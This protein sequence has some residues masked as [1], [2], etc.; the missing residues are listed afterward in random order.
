MCFNKA[1]LVCWRHRTDL[2]C[3]QAP[4]LVARSV[5]VFYSFRICVAYSNPSRD[6]CVDSALIEENLL[7][8]LSLSASHTHQLGM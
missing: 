8:H 5:A 7:G 4:F 6:F 3:L 1:V 2:F